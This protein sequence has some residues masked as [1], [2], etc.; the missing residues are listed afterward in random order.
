MSIEKSD[1]IVIIG[2]NVIKEDKHIWDPISKSA[3][4]IGFVGS[5]N[6]LGTL[7][8]LNSKINLTHISSDFGSSIQDI[9][10]FAS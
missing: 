1:K 8:S 10:Q 7:Q 3:A 4:E 9:I 6:A 2:A 5:S